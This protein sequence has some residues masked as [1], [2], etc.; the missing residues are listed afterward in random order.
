[1]GFAHRLAMGL[2]REEEMDGDT[3]PMTMVLSQAG[4][5]QSGR[6]MGSLE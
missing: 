5:A 2:G 1:M 4:V 3:G 6:G